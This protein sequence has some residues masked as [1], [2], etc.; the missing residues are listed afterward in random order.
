MYR[1]IIWKYESIEMQEGLQWHCE[2]GNISLNVYLDP[3][4]LFY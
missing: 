3:L 1:Y 4:P 2:G